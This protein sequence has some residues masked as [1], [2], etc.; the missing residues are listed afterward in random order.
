MR[1][2]Q[3]ELDKYVI[4]KSLT[5]QPEDY[6]DAK[7][8]P[9]V[10]VSLALSPSILDVICSIHFSFE[11]SLVSFC[12][13]SETKLDED[14]GVILLTS[15]VLPEQTEWNILSLLFS[16]LTL[17]GWSSKICCVYVCCNQVALRRKQNGHRVSPSDT[18]PYII[19]IE[20]VIYLYCLLLI[21]LKKF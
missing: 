17:E 7:N 4:T 10:Q 9:H 14:K 8:Q 12:H 3:I 16:N 15:Q 19:C 21:S 13:L 18:V 1:N 6:P 11:L 20:K 2:G 5:K